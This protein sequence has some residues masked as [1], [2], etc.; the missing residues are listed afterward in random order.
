MKTVLGAAVLLSSLTQV[1]MAWAVGTDAGVTVGNRATVNYAVG[2]VPQAPIESSPA[3]NSTPGVNNGADTTFVVDNRIDFTVTEL[4]GGET[5]VAPGQ[6]DAVT[7]FTVTNTGNATEGFQLSASNLVGGTVFGNT[8]STEVL[9]LLTFVDNP[10]AGGTAGAYDAA[11]DT[12]THIN[13]LAEGG[14]A[15]VFIVADV[16]NTAANGQFANVRLQAQAAVPGT[17]GATLEVED[18]TDPDTAGIDI[19]FGDAGQDAIETA[20]DQYAV[21]SASLTITK[22]SSIVRD[23]FNGTGAARKAIPG[24]VI[25]YQVEIANSGSVDAVSVQLSDTLDANLTFTA[26]EYNS[27]ASDVEIQVGAAPATY[28]V[29][30]AGADSNTDGC[31]RTGQ[32]LTVNP[33]ASITVPAG[34]TAT[35]RFRAAIN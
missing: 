24:A 11:F 18:A 7:A 21:Q 13:S 12:A 23:P 8:D 31:N 14:S 15:V 17:N 26:G 6:F 30:E 3:G 25:E 20:D 28:C 10:G 2:T 34:Q 35:V 19:V 27:G 16:D 22:S 4:S 32:M 9:N 33:T 29:A 1:Q 5:I